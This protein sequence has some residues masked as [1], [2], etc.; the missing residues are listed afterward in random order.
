[1]A[2]KTNANTTNATI[3]NAAAETELANLV[4]KYPE[5]L[6]EV[7]K[8]NEAGK[9]IKYIRAYLTLEGIDGK[10]ADAIVKAINP[11][12]KRGKGGFAADY[13]DFLAEKKRTKEEAEN[14]IMG[15][16]EYGETSGNVKNH[17]SHYLNIWELTVRIWK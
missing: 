9:P 15:K 7:Q 4:E 12:S 14:Y 10:E 3:A 2:K 8:F 6:V 17:L 1:M 11:T 16:G 5:A 13:Y